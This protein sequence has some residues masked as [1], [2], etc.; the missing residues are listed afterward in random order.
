MISFSNYKILKINTKE[1]VEKKH[2]KISSKG[3]QVQKKVV[4]LH[5]Q[6][7]NIFTDSMVRSSRG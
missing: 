3:L 2:K 5:S 7:R 1:K 6:L 4:P